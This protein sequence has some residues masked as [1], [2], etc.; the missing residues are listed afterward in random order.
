MT[1]GGFDS[2][3]G[4]TSGKPRLRPS[5]RHRRQCPRAKRT[6]RGNRHN[7][8]WR[9]HIFAIFNANVRHSNQP[10]LNSECSTGSFSLYVYNNGNGGVSSIAGYYSFEIILKAS[11]GTQLIYWWG[12]SPASPPASTSTSKVIN[13]GTIQSTFTPGQWVQFSRNLLADWTSVGLSSTTLLDKHNNARQRLPVGKQP[14]R[15]QKCSS[16][17]H[18]YSKRQQT[19]PLSFF[20]LSLKSLFP[21]HCKA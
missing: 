16:T 8:K 11:D 19:A 14:V 5:R 12:S 1:N 10:K 18:K 6:L 15:N 9:R 4:W 2:S 13:M 21:V 20:V 17:T 7:H 3:Q